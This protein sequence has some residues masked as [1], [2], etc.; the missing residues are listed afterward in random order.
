MPAMESKLAQQLQDDLLAALQHLTSEQRLQ[1]FLAHCRL[2]SELQ[3]AGRSRRTK[4]S[5][6][7]KS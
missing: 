6:Q 5:Q 3:Q 4:P 2:M 1:A 7:S